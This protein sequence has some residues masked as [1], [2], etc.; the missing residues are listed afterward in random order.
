MKTK[1]LYNDQ[2]YTE[3]V[4]RINNLAPEIEPEWGVMDV[5][6][7][8]AH[9]SEVLDAYTL[10]KPLGKISFISRLFKGMIKKVVIGNKPYSKNTPTLPQFKIV[11]PRSFE[12]EKGRLQ[13]A[14]SYFR[15]MDKK[16]AVSYIHPLFGKMTLEERG[17]AM[18][19]HLNHHLEQFKV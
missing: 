15:E 11:D 5:A 8:L 3:I 6:Q 17:W 14:I 7:M 2:I 13:E 10:R 16:I 4:E 1:S 12:Y 19:K 18:Y 9:C